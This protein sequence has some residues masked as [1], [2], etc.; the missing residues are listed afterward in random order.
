MVLGSVLIG[1]GLFFLYRL[2]QIGRG[3]IE[4][5]VLAS[6]FALI[7][8]FYGTLGGLTILIR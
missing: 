2:Y 7:V 6:A 5:N 1:V 3:E 4:T 8:G